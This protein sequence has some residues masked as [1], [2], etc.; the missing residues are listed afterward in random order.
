MSDVGRRKS[1]DPKLTDQIQASNKR[2]RGRPKAFEP[3][4]VLRGALDLFWHHGYRSTTLR[5]LESQLGIS[6]SSLYNEFGSKERILDAALDQYEA[7]IDEAVMQPLDESPTGLESISEFLA[8]LSDW[9]TRDGRRGCMITNLMA[10][11][12]GESEAVTARAAAYRARVR[13]SLHTAL[14]RARA[15][16]EVEGNGL[17]A[18]ADLLVALILGINVAARGG[19]TPTE[20]SRLLNAAITEVDSW[21]AA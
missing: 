18:R 13:A 21:R 7:D 5:D 10:E 8:A 4:T 15:L 11:D 20:V 1:G 12:G 9:V 16:G 3:D 14:E 6:Q 19:A 2:A 17:E